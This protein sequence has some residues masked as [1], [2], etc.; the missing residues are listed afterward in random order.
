VGGYLCGGH[1]QMAIDIGRRQ[2]ISVYQVDTNAGEI[3]GK[4]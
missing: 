3:A 1:R 2:F 4:L